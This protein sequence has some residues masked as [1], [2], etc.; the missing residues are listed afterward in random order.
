MASKKKCII[1][2]RNKLMS[3][4]V[5]TYQLWYLGSIHSRFK[6]MEKGE[7]GADPPPLMCVSSVLVYT[8]ILPTSLD[9]LLSCPG[10][11]W[12]FLSSFL[13]TLID[14]TCNSLYIVLIHCLK[15]F[16]NDRI[17]I[18]LEQLMKKKVKV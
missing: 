18:I 10:P 12:P 11:H 13:M 17:R 9:S 15:T 8:L 14:Y 3:A 2:L 16:E 5:L 7:S 4:M 1:V 6:K